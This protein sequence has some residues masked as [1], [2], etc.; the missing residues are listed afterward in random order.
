MYKKREREKK[1]MKFIADLHLLENQIQVRNTLLNVPGSVW[2]I[3]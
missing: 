3:S 1:T 2:M